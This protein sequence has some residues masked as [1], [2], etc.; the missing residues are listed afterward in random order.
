MSA[1]AIVA[2]RTAR[3][4]PLPLNDVLE[5]ALYHPAHGF[6]ETGGSAGR[7]QGDFLTSPE[8][9]ALFGAVVANALDG[10]WGQMGRPVPFLVVEAGAGPGTLARMV[11]AAQPAC[12]E[13]LR[14]VLVERAAKQ[15]ARHPEHLPVEDPALALPPVDPDSGL[16]LS[17]APAG[18]ICVS[19]ADLPRPSGIPAVVLANELLDN[20]PFDLAERRHG[21]WFEVRVGL[22]RDRGDESD[23]HG[24][25]VTTPTAHTRESQRLRRRDSYDVGSMTETQPTET[26]P[27]RQSAHALCEV[28]VPLDEPRAGWLD[29]LA[30]DAPEGARVPLQDRAAGWLRSALDAAG[31]GGRVV[32]FD[33]GMS[34]AELARRPRESW[35]RTYRGHGRG[36]GHLADLGSQ[37]VTC[38]VAVD[39][40]GLVKPLERDMSQN[41]WLE[42]W[43]IRQLVAEARQ[44]WTDRAHIGDLE[45]LTAQSRVNESRALLD[46]E[47]LGAFRVLEWPGK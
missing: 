12:S 22:D 2:E 5:V 33:Y 6:Y 11:L 1:A 4:G 35:L 25:G 36:T 9:G 17:E 39:Q 24:R 29:R 31:P 20:I 21:E 28:L 30:P 43:G 40:L 18:P 41:A 15:R 42:E 10:W 32:T 46:P 37:D 34:T 14:Y 8:V 3:Q 45:A 19:L 44:L 38:E 47:G 16:A 7:R 26:P 23:P 27:A 13:A